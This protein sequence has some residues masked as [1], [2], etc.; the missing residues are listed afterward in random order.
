MKK[1]A[2]FLAFLAGL[3]AGGMP[4]KAQVVEARPIQIEVVISS[5]TYKAHYATVAA[6]G[7]APLDPKAVR[8]MC[9]SGN[10]NVTASGARTKPGVTI[11]ADKPIPFGT[12]A[13]IIG[14][15]GIR[16][17]EDRG[18]KIKGNRIDICFQ[19]R[20]QALE[21]GKRTVTVLFFLEEEL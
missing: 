1:I 6:T 9:Y 16:I 12:K 17:V 5:E 14:L 13:V 7:Y 10:P 2:C 8:G 11:A 20:K 19:T 3:I 15:P 4:I 21:W 18:G